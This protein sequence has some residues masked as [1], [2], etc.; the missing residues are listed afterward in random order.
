[1]G[2]N[3]RQGTRNAPSLLDVAQQRTLFWDGRSTS[4]ESQSLDPLLNP[5][6]HGLADEADL[7]ARV[8][9]NDSY[10]G[11]FR[12]LWG[13]SRDGITTQHIAQAI[14]AYERT[15]VS[16]AT[17]FDRFREGNTAALPAAARRGWQLF[18]EQAQCARCHLPEG[19]RPLF[20]DHQFHSLAIGIRSIERKLPALVERLVQLHKDGRAFDRALS[21]DA[22][23][24]ALGRF[25]VTLDPADIGK[26]KT[27]GLRNVAL[28]APYMHDGSVATLAEAVDLEVYYRGTLDGKPLILTPS[29]REDLVAFLHSL[30]SEKLPVSPA[31]AR[32]TTSRAGSP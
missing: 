24:A 25:A 19:A 32:Q 29:E 16:G 15:L 28:T 26:F 21:A 9:S 18:N 12:A 10:A 6:E 2:S 3:G 14:A 17:P 5:A 11:A 23:I 30:T 8:R 4:L 13:V 7:L 31:T 22:D 1:M 20:T 27:P